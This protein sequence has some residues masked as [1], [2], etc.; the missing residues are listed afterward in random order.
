MTWTTLFEVAESATP[1][2]RGEV[3]NPRRPGFSADFGL[4][5]VQQTMTHK[6][7]MIASNSLTEDS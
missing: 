3:F 1:H 6:T 5:R 2:L 7:N 4:A